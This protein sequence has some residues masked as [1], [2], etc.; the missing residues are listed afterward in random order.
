MKL[1]PI[2]H[3]CMQFWM[4]FRRNHSHPLAPSTTI[5]HF[6]VSPHQCVVF[7]A[8]ASFLDLSSCR[9]KYVGASWKM[10]D[11]RY[12]LLLSGPVLVT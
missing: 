4:E 3:Y 9:P 10:V 11:R 6:G 1:P 7:F 8:R 2:Y 5:S 12:A